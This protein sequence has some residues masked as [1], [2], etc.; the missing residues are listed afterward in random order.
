MEEAIRNGFL[1]KYKYEPFF[2]IFTDH[3]WEEYKDLTRKIHIKGDNETINTKAALKRQLLKDQAE[4]KSEAVLQIVNKLILNQSFKNTLIYC[5]KGLNDED[6]RFIYV[7]QDKLKEI[8]PTLNTATFLGETQNRDLLLKDFEDDSVDMLLAIKCLDEGVNI[9]KTMN[10]IFVA[11]GQNY[12]EYI[13]RRGRVLRNYRK[14]NFIKEYAN[15]Y[16]V[17]ILPSLEHFNKD[18]QIAENLIISEFMRLYEFYNLSSDKFITYKKINDELEKYNL[19]EQY[20][21]IKTQR[22]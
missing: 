20:I 10:A 11:S 21:R 1:C 3:E 4:N 15:L 17:V 12:R 6:E 8:Y 9:P 18:R 19:T 2:V 16:D 5:P 13:Q 22:N 14:G 7:L